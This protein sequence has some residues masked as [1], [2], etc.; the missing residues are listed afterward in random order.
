MYKNLS[1]YLL[2]EE[3]N[4]N[5]T[6]INE[7]PNGY[8]QS[9]FSK[10]HFLPNQVIIKL[11]GEVINH[12]TSN[13]SVQ[14]DLNRHIDPYE[15][16]GKYLNH[17][18]NPNVYVQTDSDGFP[19]L[20]ALTSIK[21]NEEIVYSYFMTEYEW[22]PIAQEKT[23]KCACQS[24]NCVQI[25]RAYKQLSPEEKVFYKQHKNLSNYLYQL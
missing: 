7:S 6:Y 21:E 5:N 8:G 15:W 2:I 10:K 14:I 24:S 20:R 12:Q 3:F 23:I 16:G 4:K 18:C 11:F 1:T 25:I 9:V 19:L 17:S 22:S 13:Y